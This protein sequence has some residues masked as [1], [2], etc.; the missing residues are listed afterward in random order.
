MADN[1]AALSSTR[2]TLEGRS[3]RRESAAEPGLPIFPPA[4]QTLPVSPSPEVLPAPDSS[5][6]KQ[7]KIQRIKPCHVASAG[8]RCLGRDPGCSNAKLGREALDSAR[9]GAPETN[10]SVQTRSS[11]ESPPLRSR[12]IRGCAAPEDWSV[13]GRQEFVGASGGSRAG[14]RK[15]RR[16]I[17]VLIRLGE[18][19]KEGLGDASPGERGAAHEVAAGERPFPEKIRRTDQEVPPPFLNARTTVPD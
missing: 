4:S 17:A 12:R 7:G 10:R 11:A 18:V 2:P 13:P 6:I 19:G 15:E 5:P 16:E 9:G 8:W 3:R 1:L 14:D